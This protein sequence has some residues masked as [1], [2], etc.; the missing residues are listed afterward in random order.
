MDWVPSSHEQPLKCHDD[1]PSGDA[2]LWYGDGASLVPSIRF[3]KVEPPAGAEPSIGVLA[4]SVG[5]NGL[6][7]CIQHLH[8]EFI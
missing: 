5:P 7:A 2:L 3:G 6:A 8:T 1:P 4:A